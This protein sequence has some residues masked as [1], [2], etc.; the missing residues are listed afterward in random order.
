MVT[1]QDWRTVI[2][3]NLNGTYHLVHAVLPQMRAQ[4]DGLII[5]VTS[6]AGKRTISTLAGSSYC[7]SKFAM[8][9]LGEAINLEEYENGIRERPARLTTQ[10]A[11]G[12]G[13][14]V[15]RAAPLPRFGPSVISTSE[16]LPT[17]SCMPRL[18]LD[19]L[20]P[21]R[22][23]PDHPLRCPQGVRTSARGRWRQ[24]S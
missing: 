5:N 7:A 16:L 2:D 18:D 15:T 1:A 3:V 8:N 11:Q 14:A 21:Y 13:R 19:E 17:F 4:Q 9:S 24:R 23:P 22:S 12:Q 20:L 10:P 6:I